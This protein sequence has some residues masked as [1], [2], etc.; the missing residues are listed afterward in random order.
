M[1]TQTYVQQLTTFCPGP[2]LNETSVNKG[3]L[4]AVT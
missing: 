4:Q 3:S 1:C 2:D